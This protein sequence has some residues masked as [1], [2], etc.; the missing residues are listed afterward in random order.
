MLYEAKIFN[1]PLHADI[2]MSVFDSLLNE[3]SLEL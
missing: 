3:N 2:T 1:K